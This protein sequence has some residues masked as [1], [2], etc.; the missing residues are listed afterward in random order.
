MRQRDRKREMEKLKY[1]YIYIHKPNITLVIT[2]K[3]QR[4]SGVHSLAVSDS[5]STT[6]NVTLRLQ[7]HSCSFSISLGC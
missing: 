5:N 2:A 1:I 4:K 6:N 7:L 3:N